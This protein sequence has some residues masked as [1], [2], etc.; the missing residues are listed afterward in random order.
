MAESSR[1][2]ADSSPESGRRAADA[3]SHRP[4]SRGGFASPGSDSEYSF[5][6]C[7]VSLR[8]DYYG[9]IFCRG[10][11]AAVSRADMA[12]PG[13]AVLMLVRQQPLE[14]RDRRGAIAHLPGG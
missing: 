13:Q 5:H 9:K 2:V 14:L 1:Y 3:A 4:E 6:G 8:G 12:H 7:S 11:E 10:D